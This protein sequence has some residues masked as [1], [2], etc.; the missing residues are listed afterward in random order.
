M[1]IFTAWIIDVGYHVAK[2]KNWFIN[3]DFKIQPLD[4][5]GNVA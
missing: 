2:Q 3:R 4:G 1:S 5:Y